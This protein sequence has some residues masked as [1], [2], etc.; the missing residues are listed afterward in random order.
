ME[1]LNFQFAFGCVLK[2]CN[3]NETHPFT[4]C[5]AW[6]SGEGY[7]ICRVEALRG[8]KKK[9][10]TILHRFHVI[11]RICTYTGLGTIMGNPM[12]NGMEAEVI[13]AR[14]VQREN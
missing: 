11:G 9:E 10:T 6:L 12:G 2:A 4:I 13:R 5:A 8:K 14:I 7:H 3:N 1:I